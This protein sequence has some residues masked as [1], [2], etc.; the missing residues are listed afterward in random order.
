[1]KGNKPILY[2]KLEVFSNENDESVDIRGGVPILEYRESVLSPYITIDLSIIDAGTAS[3]AKDG[4]RGTIGLLESIKL[5]A[6][7]KLKLILEDQYGNKIDLSKDTDLKVAKTTFATTSNRQSTVVI[8]VVSK[9]AYDN[10]WSY[11]NDTMEW[12]WKSAE[13]EQERIKDLAVAN[14]DKEAREYQAQLQSAS[15]GGQAVGS[16][17]GTLGGAALQFGFGKVF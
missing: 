14:L 3:A 13:S 2:K 6:D 17:I 5:Q 1:M 7:E 10:L 9:E 8:R 4:S 16:L 12:A 15:Q 11:Y